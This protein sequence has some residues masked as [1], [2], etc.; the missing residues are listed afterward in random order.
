MVYELNKS[1]LEANTYYIPTWLEMLEIVNKAKFLQISRYI[2][3]T[4][5]TDL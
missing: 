3:T 1:V 4:K 2:A 5:K